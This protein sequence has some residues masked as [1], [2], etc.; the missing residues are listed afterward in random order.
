LLNDRSDD[1]AKRGI[2]V[3]PAENPRGATAFK[4]LVADPPASEPEFLAMWKLY[5]LTLVARSFRQQKI[6]GAEAGVVTDAVD[7]AK[8]LPSAGGLRAI[9]RSAL[10]YARRRLE[11]ESYEAGLKLDPSTS[12]P[13]GVTGKITL[14]EPT[15]KAR[16]IGAASADELLERA[17]KALAA[18][19]K[20]IWLL[21]DRLD[22]AFAEDATLE[23]NA[24]RALFHV[25]LDLAG[26]DH[27]RLKIFLRTDIWRRITSGGFREASHITRQATIGWDSTSLMNLVVRRALRNAGV[28]DFYQVDEAQTL[29]DVMSQQRLFYRM[30]PQQVEAGPNKP[31]TFD[32]MLGRTHDGSN[33]NAP[34]ELIHLLDE[35]RSA[36]LRALEVGGNEPADEALFSGSALKAALPEVSRARLEQTLYAEYP[37]Y[38]DQIQRL[39][40]EKTQQSPQTLCRIWRIAE[41]DA[42]R[43]AEE[44]ADVGFFE[45]RG[46][47]EQPLYWVPFLYRDALQMVQGAAD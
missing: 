45:R 34:R 41:Q 35:A 3:V 9:L 22:V 32:W 15:T 27:I 31:A 7:E 33:E 44:L 47:K 8:L 21:L 37:Q 38:K 46:T 1:L 12:A 17:N 19:G 14:R 42:V 10:D 2:V 13:I 29:S 18:S 39:E 24:L 4:D 6:G 43:I 30:F 23:Q 16:E 36:Q 11:F 5:F 40:G 26:L 25:Y 20:K 28:R